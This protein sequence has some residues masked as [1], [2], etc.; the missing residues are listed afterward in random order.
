MIGALR[1]VSART[2]PLAAR[3]ARNIHIVNEV[4]N[5]RPSKLFRL[6]PELIPSSSYRTCLSVSCLV[7]T[8]DMAR[9]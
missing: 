1:T 4:G 3:N 6:L 8:R 5:A 9:R 7:I 2:G